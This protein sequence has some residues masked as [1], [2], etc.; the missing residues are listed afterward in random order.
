[1]NEPHSP[2]LHGWTP[3][4]GQQQFPGIGDAFAGP[5]AVI[6][7]TVIPNQVTA[8]ATKLPF[9]INISNMAD[10]KALVDRMGGVEGILSTMGK[11]QKFVSTMQQIAPMVKLF[12]GNKGSKASTANSSKSSTPRRRPGSRRPS[13]S[14]ARTRRP[15]KRR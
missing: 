8:S 12:M 6:N 2:S 14:K 11:F 10:V 1:M 5:P 4:F 15:A 9:N 13:G 3:G 7:P